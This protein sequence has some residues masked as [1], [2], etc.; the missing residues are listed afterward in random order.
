MNMLSVA[1]FAMIM[2]ACVAA[3]GT[4]CTS[5]TGLGDCS[6]VVHSVCQNVTCNNSV[7]TVIDI[8]LAA[9]HACGPNKMCDGS[10][11]CVPA[12]G[13]TSCSNC[14]GSYVVNALSDVN[15]CGTCGKVCPGGS[16]ALC[17]GGVCT[18]ACDSTHIDCN[19]NKE[20]G[21][22]AFILSDTNNC[23][24]CGIVCPN[25]GSGAV[26]CINGACTCT[27]NI[28][29]DCC[30]G[31]TCAPSLPNTA[32]YC[33]KNACVSNVCVLAADHAGKACGSS[34]S[35]SQCMYSQPICDSDG[36]CSITQRIPYPSGTS[37]AGNCSDI[38]CSGRSPSCTQ[39][40][41]LQCDGSGNCYCNFDNGALCTA[42]I[43]ELP[44][45]G[46]CDSNAPSSCAQCNSATDL[47]SMC[48]TTIPPTLWYESYL[49]IF[50]VGACSVVC[51]SQTKGENCSNLFC[52]NHTIQASVSRCP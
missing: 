1:S 25:Y 28:D 41:T 37:C 21:C 16:F 38:G 3:Q 35:Y 32:A 17:V 5:C 43:Q 29:R 12:S 7:C 40:N 48:N 11:S 22:E 51:S 10:G 8:P 13:Y 36:N 2:A 24:G 14:T 49:N 18:Y 45:C 52:A 4:G 30:P 20:D 31:G 47:T 42:I 46:V 6:S 33:K 9:Q 15:N 34:T 23:G 26:S 44:V 19:H 39:C 27:C 50:G